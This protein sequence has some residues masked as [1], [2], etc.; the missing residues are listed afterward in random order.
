MVKLWDATRLDEQHLDGTANPACPRCRASSPG[1]C[2]NVAFSP[3][4]RCLASGGEGT[5]SEIWDVQTGKEARPPLGDTAEDVCAV[6]FSPDGRWVASAGEDSTVR[7]WDRD[8]GKP[9][10]APSA[11]T[12]AS[13]AAWRS[14][15]TAGDCISGS[16]GLHGQGLG[17]DATV[18]TGRAD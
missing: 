8:A 14:A 13:S 16:R 1:V 9:W 18:M 10:S 12:R 5:Q 4:G 15:P 2:L 17:H 3:D 11:A 7:V 6:A